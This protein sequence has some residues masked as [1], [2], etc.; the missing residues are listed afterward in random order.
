MAGSRAAVSATRG[1]QRQGITDIMLVF[2]HVKASR[3]ERHYPQNL[4]VQL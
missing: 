3:L 4:E 1:R 2:N